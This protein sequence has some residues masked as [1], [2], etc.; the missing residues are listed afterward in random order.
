MFSIKV[1]GSLAGYFASS[2]G[3]RQGDPFS[4]Y[5]FV[6]VME[7]LSLKLN[8]GSM[9]QEFKFHWRTKK[10][11]VTH[12]FFADDILI[13]CH[14]S[15]PT[16]SIIHSCIS[17]FSLYSG[18]IPN[19]QKSQCFLANTDQSTSKSILSL[20]GF[21]AGRMPTKY[22]GVPLISSKLSYQDFI[23]LIN[24]ITQRVSS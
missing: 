3:L 19:V 2:R 11:R 18:L 8:E 21:S 22:L 14:A 16:F 13:F 12:L 10:A 1:N 7:M 4:P 20:L 9:K 17:S 5:L 6:L 15:M 24:R 23:P